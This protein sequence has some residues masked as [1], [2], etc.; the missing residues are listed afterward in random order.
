MN[1]DGVREVHSIDSGN[2]LANQGSVWRREGILNTR[3]EQA[4]AE[5]NRNVTASREYEERF[6]INMREAVTEDRLVGLYLLSE[7][8]KCEQY[9]VF[10]E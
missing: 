7:R 5:S 8:L 6:S 9:L 10:L 1:L 3:N 4:W 2:C